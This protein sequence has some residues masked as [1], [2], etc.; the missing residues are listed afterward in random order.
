MNGGNIIQ[1]GRPSTITI[2][3]TRVESL[4]NVGNP[5]ENIATIFNFLLTSLLRREHA[6]LHVEVRRLATDTAWYLRSRT[7]EGESDDEIVAVLPSAIVSSCAARLAVA[8]GIHHTDG[9]HGRVV[10]SQGGRRQDCLVFL[11]NC[12]DSGFWIRVYAQAVQATNPLT[13]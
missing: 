12:R 4:E 2:E 9:G 13:R 3:I 7:K 10:L 8:M 1:V 6:L 11:S 5:L